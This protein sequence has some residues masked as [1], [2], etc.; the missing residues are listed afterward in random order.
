MENRL[1]FVLES[2][3]PGPDGEKSWS[4]KYP[5][6]G[7]ML[8][9]PIDLHSDILQYDASLVPL[10]FQ[11][12][13][14]SDNEQ[15]I[16]TNDGHSGEKEISAIC[17]GMSEHPQLL[18]LLSSIGRDAAPWMYPGEG[19]GAAGP[20][21]PRDAWTIQEM[22]GATLPGQHLSEEAHLLGGGRGQA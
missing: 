4:K 18:G 16:L 20:G 5:A 2:P 14:V 1:N 17:K 6:C 8:Q 3:L 19:E 15:F 22:P 12:Y 11:G 9:S 10:G 21:E 13:N 7:G